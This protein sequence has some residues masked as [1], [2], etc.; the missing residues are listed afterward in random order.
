MGDQGPFWRELLRPN[1]KLK[2]NGRAVL[3]NV[4]PFLSLR[5]FDKLDRA[6]SSDRKRL[7]AIDTS[8]IF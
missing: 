1:N 5:V 8:G 6:L 4:M 3:L 2:I 7:V